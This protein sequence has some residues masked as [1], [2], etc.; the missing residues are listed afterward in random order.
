[1]KRLYRSRRDRV[2]GGVCGG[3]A[4]YFGI[5]PVIIRVIWTLAIIFGGTGIIAYIICWLVIPEEPM[6]MSMA[7]QSSTANE[8]LP[9]P[10]SAI[11]P[12]IIGAILLVIGVALLFSNLGLFTFGHFWRFFW[13]LVIILIGVLMLLATTKKR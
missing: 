3:I 9:K 12:V 10:A 6:E 7:T 11:V 4:S 1:M 13:P 5:D 8:D 2:I